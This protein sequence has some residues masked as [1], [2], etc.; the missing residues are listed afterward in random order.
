MFEVSQ[1]T[2]SYDSFKAVGNVSFT[3]GKGEFVGLPGHNGAGKTTNWGVVID[4]IDP[5]IF[6][7]IYH[8]KVVT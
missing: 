4:S 8:A 6:I 7:A 3:I 5:E 1:L 2:R